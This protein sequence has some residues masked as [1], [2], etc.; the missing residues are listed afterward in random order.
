M[1]WAYWARGEQEKKKERDG[2]KNKEREDKEEREGE[3]K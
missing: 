2:K 1:G 3:R